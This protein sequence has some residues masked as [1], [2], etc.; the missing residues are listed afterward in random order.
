M[1]SAEA[2]K[3]TTTIIEESVKNANSGVEIAGEVSRV[4]NE[5]VSGI[6]GT[7]DLVNEISA[8][9]QEQAQGIE[10]INTAVVEMDKVTQQ[11]AANAEESAS[12]S[13]ELSAQAESMN[14]LVGELVTMVG[15]SGPAGISRSGKRHPINTK[16]GY[17]RARNVHDV[18]DSYAA[19]DTSDT[20]F[21][22]IALGAD[23]EG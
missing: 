5:I 20:M 13:E 21:H 11:N 1:R 3:N 17:V 9:S 14:E 2:A 23:T 18:Q 8:A 6:G 16:A 10:Q 4:L 12:A 15:G 7:T 19:P 22:R